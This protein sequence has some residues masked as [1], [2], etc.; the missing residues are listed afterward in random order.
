MFH[1]GAVVQPLPNAHLIFRASSQTAGKCWL[2]GLELALKSSNV[3]LRFVNLKKV[4]MDIYFLLQ[5]PKYF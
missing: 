3:L 2:D 5:L 4:Y 1:V